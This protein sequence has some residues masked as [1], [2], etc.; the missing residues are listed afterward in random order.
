MV[1]GVGVAGMG[2]GVSHDAL[3]GS[4]SRRVWINFL[5]SLSFPMLGASGYLWR[6]LHNRVHHTFTNMHPHDEDLQASPL[7][8]LS[9]GRP[10]H[11][12]HRWQH[13]Y[14][15]PLYALT[16]LNWAVLKDFQYML[17]RNLG[18]VTPGPHALR[19]WAGLIL[20]KVLHFGWTVVLPI[21]ILQPVWWH[22]VLCFLTMHLT[23]GFLLAIVFQLAHV[24]EQ[25]AFV[26]LEREGEPAESW[27]VH[28]L[29]NTCD[30]ARGRRLL[31]WF[32][33]GLNYQVEHHLFPQ[34][35][36][37]HYAALSPMVEACARRHGV[38]FHAAPSFVSAVASHARTLRRLGRPGAPVHEPVLTP[39][40]S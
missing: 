20:G 9:P 22:F 4:V 7:L 11:A 21:L 31:T 35:N 12:V 40:S 38:P 39:A 23:A 36:S 29:R 19:D 30:F 25:T 33:G 15:W 27:A 13:V 2:F 18:P 34:V 3:H 26:P 10:R 32:V 16:T 28:Q 14:A 5:L 24:V 37:T 1:V 6:L 17:R 8:R